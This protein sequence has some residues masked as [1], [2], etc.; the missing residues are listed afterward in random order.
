[1]KL[2]TSPYICFFIRWVVSRILHLDFESSFFAE[3]DE[4]LEIF[5]IS[6]EIIILNV[7][8]LK[9][10]FHISPIQ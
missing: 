7:W 5:V 6:F 1:M 8:I 10:Y 3:N 9:E 2:L 4:A